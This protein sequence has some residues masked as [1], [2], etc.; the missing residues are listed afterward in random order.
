M[1]DK[2]FRPFERLDEQS[3]PILGTG[4]GLT[5]T[6]KLVTLM[7]G[8]IGVNSTP[9]EGSTFWVE[10][11][12]TDIAPQSSVIDTGSFPVVT[13]NDQGSNLVYV[14]DNHANQRLMRSIIHA[15]TH[16]HLSIA[17]NGQEGLQLIK[18]QKPDLVMLDLK[19]P[20]MDGFEILRKMKQSPEMRDI[21]VMAITADALENNAEEALQAGFDDFCTKPA[22][23][24]ILVKK[25]QSLLKNNDQQQASNEPPPLDKKVAY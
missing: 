6:H 7:N 10:L 11:P 9:G 25:I 23:P 3:G 18:D 15:H 2:I 21:P 14:E 22:R 4:I 17:S 19:L 20:G 24:G 13:E 5:I 1:E 12:L 16:Y 8:S